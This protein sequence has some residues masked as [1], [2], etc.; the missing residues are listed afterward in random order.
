MMLL[1]VNINIIVATD[2]Q[3]GVGKKNRL[4]YD[5]ARLELLGGV[6]ARL[7]DQCACASCRGKEATVCSRKV[8]ISTKSHALLMGRNTWDTLPKW[9]RCRTNLVLGSFELEGAHVFDSYYEA[10]LFLEG[11]HEELHTCWVLGGPE[12]FRE[13]LTSRFTD[14][15][16]ITKVYEDFGC[17]AS[18]PSLDEADDW[19]LEEGPLPAGVQERDGVQFEQL[20]Y[21]RVGEDP[22]GEGLTSCTDGAQIFIESATSGA[23]EKPLA[24]APGREEPSCGSQGPL[25]LW[26][27]V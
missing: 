21:R 9:H 17:E 20:V 14:R 8:P 11:R 5:L 1:G 13:A 27:D 6:P 16:Y 24:A 7:P 2:E 10:L 3:G 19:E 15:V 18:F 22:H 4:K 26:M 23:A 12:V 25:D